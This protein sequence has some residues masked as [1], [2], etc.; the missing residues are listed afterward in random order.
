MSDEDML[1]RCVLALATLALLPGAGAASPEA[2]ACQTVR[3]A[4]PGWADIDATN[5]LAVTLLRALGY[6]PTVQT[7]SVP[8]T[9][10]GLKSGQLDVFLGNWM[11]AQRELVEPFLRQGQVERL[12]TNLEKA[13]FTLAVPE[14]VAQ[15]GVRTFADLQAHAERFGRR[16]YGI[17][18]GAPANQILRRMMATKAFGLEGWTLMESG[19]SALLAQLERNFRAADKPWMVFLAWEPHVINTRFPI[20]YLEGGDAYFGPEFGAATVATVSRKGWAAE[21]P[22]LGRLFAQL[23]FSVGLENELL[24]QTV[25]ARVEAGR[26]ATEWLRRNPAVAERWL[27]GVSTQDG[28][29]GVQA[30]RQSLGV[31]AR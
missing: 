23:R 24:Q 15:A 6:R 4:S 5:A 3:L 7:L 1:K 20:R 10:Q 11:P 21:C 22:N 19:D 18:P 8:L 26:A 30:L 13:R 14:Y 31:A 12:A 28:R 27:Q 9:Y 17:E 25:G 29:D 16:F 2:P